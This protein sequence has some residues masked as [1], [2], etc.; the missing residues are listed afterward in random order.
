M[1]VDNVYPLGL[2]YWFVCVLCLVLFLR[3]RLEW[4]EG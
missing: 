4:G 1:T 2:F 3:D